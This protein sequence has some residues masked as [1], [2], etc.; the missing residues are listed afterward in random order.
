MIHLE[1]LHREWCLGSYKLRW[2]ASKLQTSGT[3]WRKRGNQCC[4]RLYW[5]H[6]QFWDRACQSEPQYTG[7][8][9]PWGGSAPKKHKRLA[10][11]V[12]GL[13][14][15]VHH[16]VDLNRSCQFTVSRHIVMKVLL[17]RMQ[18]CVNVLVAK[19]C[20]SRVPVSCGRSRDALVTETKVWQ[21]VTQLSKVVL[22]FCNLV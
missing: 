22:H 15:S 9:S 21:L 2:W 17:K 10:F 3:T 12:I 6:F 4:W 13:A 7:G 5:H 8:T 19:L 16:W 20:F 1:K 14:K 18:N 11:T